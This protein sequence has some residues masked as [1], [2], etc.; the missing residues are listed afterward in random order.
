MLVPGPLY[1]LTLVTNPAAVALFQNVPA[2]PNTGTI[3]CSQSREQDCPF[4]SFDSDARHQILLHISSVSCCNGR[5]LCTLTHLILLLLPDFCTTIRPKL[6]PL[7]WHPGRPG[8]VL[9]LPPWSTT[10]NL[11]EPQ[12]FS[13]LAP[14][15]TQNRVPV[16]PD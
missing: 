7:F 4:W 10:L 9:S 14:A 16:R 15:Q 12:T 1:E 8:A 3:V 11:V 5:S 13:V 2:G 6:D